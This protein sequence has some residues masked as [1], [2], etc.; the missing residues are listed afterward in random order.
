MLTLAYRQEVAH[1]GITVGLVH[2]SWIDTDLVRGAE[3][4]LPSFQDLR[5]RLPYP[6]NATTSVDEAAAAIVDALARRRGRVYVPRAVAGVNWAK[7]I[8]NSPLM[9]PWTRRFAAKSVPPLEKE[10]EALGRQNQLMR[11]TGETAGEAGRS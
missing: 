7:A 10:V 1:L 4:E 11:D 8:L 3:A 6:G 5:R 2:P 9:W